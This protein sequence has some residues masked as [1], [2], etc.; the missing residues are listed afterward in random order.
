[1]R[2]ADPGTPAGSPAQLTDRIRHKLDT[3]II[4][5]LELREASLREA[6]EFLKRKSVEFDTAEPDPTK[7]GVNIVLRIDGQPTAAPPANS[8]PG[9]VEPNQPNPPPPVPSVDPNEARIT[10]ALTNVP[11]GEALRYVTNLAGLKYKIEGDAVTVVPLSTPIDTLV[12]KEYKVPPGFLSEVPATNAPGDALLPPGGA[13]GRDERRVRNRQTPGGT[14]LPDG[15]RH[16]FP[17]GLLRRLPALER[18]A[19]RQEHAGE[20]GRGRHHH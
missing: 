6:I 13:R 15:R 16:H 3:I 10:I 19:H 14:R 18:P 8:I 4:P 20:P 5:K 9:L 7:R 12:T 1:M 17:A 11:L 2:R